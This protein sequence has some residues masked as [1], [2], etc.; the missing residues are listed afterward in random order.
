MSGNAFNMKN[1]SPLLDQATVL[2]VETMGRQTG[3]LFHKFYELEDDDEIMTGARALLIDF[4]GP[5]MTDKKL[6]KLRGRR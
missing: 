5:K 2:L 3:E 6:K 4:I 1:Q